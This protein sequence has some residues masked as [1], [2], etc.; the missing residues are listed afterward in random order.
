[1]DDHFNHVLAECH[2]ISNDKMPISR[3]LLVQLLKVSEETFQEYNTT[4]F[5]SL[6]ITALGGMYENQ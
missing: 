5:H 2:R 4:L 1:M 6:L 3:S